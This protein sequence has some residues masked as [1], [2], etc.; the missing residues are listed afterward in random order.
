MCVF[1]C[2]TN[3]FDRSSGG[4]LES[5]SADTAAFNLQSSTM[6][7][8]MRIPTN[9]PRDL[10]LRT[11]LQDCSD[12]E[13]R[14]LSR[15]HC[16]AGYTLPEEENDRKSG[17]PVFTRHHI[18]D[19]NYH[20]S[21][22][23]SRPNRWWVVLQT[24]TTYDSATVA[25]SSTDKSR[26]TKEAEP[27]LPASFKEFSTT[28][29]SHGVPIYFERWQRISPLGMQRERRVVLWRPGSDS[30]RTAVLLVIGNHFACC[31]DRDY[32]I[33]RRILRTVRNGFCNARIIRL[34]F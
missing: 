14:I 19:W 29:D 31:V 9:R 16:F 27:Y 2:P 12:F 30:Y 24:P 6:F 17:E 10:C 28:R 23:R 3:I 25:T 20:P 34:V 33:A 5:T 22:P 26:C 32:S 4:W 1:Y 7:I 15:Q 13:L 11:C 18:V 21:F 8:D